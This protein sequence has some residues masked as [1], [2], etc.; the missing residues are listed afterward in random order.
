MYKGTITRIYKVSYVSTNQKYSFKNRYILWLTYFIVTL[1]FGA[2][3]QFDNKYFIN[4]MYTITTITMWT[5]IAKECQNSSFLYTP[6]TKL[7]KHVL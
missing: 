7:Y 3:L 6:T 5:H 4:L 1:L 2:I